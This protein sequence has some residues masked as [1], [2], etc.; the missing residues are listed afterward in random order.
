V[1]KAPGRLDRLSFRR[2]IW[3]ILG[4]GWLAAGAGT[5][6]RALSSQGSAWHALGAALFVCTAISCVVVGLRAGRKR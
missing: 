4:A 6:L 1:K 5:S 3:F 2:G